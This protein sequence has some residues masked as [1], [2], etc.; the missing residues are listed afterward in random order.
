MKIVYKQ[1]IV[2]GGKTISIY[3]ELIIEIMNRLIKY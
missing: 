1:F 2:I 3:P